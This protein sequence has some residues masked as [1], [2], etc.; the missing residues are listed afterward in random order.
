MKR[1]CV[2]IPCPRIARLTTS[3]I[4]VC[5]AIQLKILEYG[6][7]PEVLERFA[8]RAL[9]ESE[10]DGREGGHATAVEGQRGGESGNRGRGS[11][12]GG[13]GPR[14]RG[15]G[16]GASSNQAG[17]TPAEDGPPRKKVMTETNSGEGAA[18]PSD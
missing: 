6:D 16:R 15:R 7:R 1:V 12:R 10:E 4:I 2:A 3:H 13:G 18:K 17:A 8:K 11:G 14:G 5:Y 9:E